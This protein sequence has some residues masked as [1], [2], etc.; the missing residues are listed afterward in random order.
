MAQP[1]HILIIGAGLIGLATARACVNSGA[2]VTLVERQSFTGHGA[3]FANSGMIHPSQAWPWVTGDLNIGAQ[4]QAARNVADLARTSVTS[5]KDRMV[6]LGLSDIKRET[7]CYKIFESHEAR[8]LAKDQYSQID[9]QTQDSVILG[10]P[11][12]IFPND[13]SGSAYDWSQAETQALRQ[14]GV[15]LQTN[16]QVTL[17]EKDGHATV[18][19]DECHVRADHI[20]L[21]TGYS[22]NK[23]LHPLKLNLPIKPVRGFALDFDMAGL[24]VTSLPQA[25]IMDAKSHS[26]LTLFGK[27]LRLSGTLNEQTAHPLWQRW[28]HLSPNLMSNVSDP[29]RIWSGFRPVSELGRPIITQ[30]P[31]KNL[32]VNSGHG[33]MGWTLCMAS[34]QLMADMVIAGQSNSN[35][36]W[37]LN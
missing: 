33:H 20:I 6:K 25:P 23:L 4:L 18:S 5:L 36:S 29:K 27:T 21:C 24:D 32:W 9:I 37:P 10:R 14:D 15:T 22:T 1:Q 12:L 2:K 7:A 17:G 34:G 35:F 13:F 16:A 11:A 19:I 31:L 28:C 3:G 26:A 8:N 30:S